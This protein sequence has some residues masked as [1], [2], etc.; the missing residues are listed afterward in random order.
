MET[1]VKTSKDGTAS[2]VVRRVQSEKLGI[3]GSQHWWATSSPETYHIEFNGV[4]DMVR[5]ATEGAGRTDL[6]PFNFFNRAEFVGRNFST[7]A[8]IVKATDN[9]W[10]LGVDR[11][12]E[13]SRE[14]EREE[15]PRPT[16]IKRRRVWDETAGDEID[17]DR[18]RA[19]DPYFRDSK[20]QHASGPRVITII[21]QLGQNAGMKSDDL[22]WRGA[23]AITL[24][25]I[26]EDAGYRTEIIAFTSGAGTTQNPQC[27]NVLSSVRLKEAGDML[28]V[29]SLV[30]VTSG[31]FF[32]TVSFASWTVPGERLS[33]GLGSMI[34]ATPEMVAYLAPGARPW[35]V[36]GV[37]N[38]ENS[39]RLARELLATLVQK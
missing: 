30:N 21:I 3:V 35:V 36:S 6:Y 12:E 20:R 28:D 24:A 1:Q 4:G 5:L 38:K 9:V 11:V 39:L 18:Y 23:L 14:L 7:F 10:T 17:F 16:V 29:S 15:L 31:W 32:R 2:A 34:E 26:V 8:E 37:Y 25:R 13:M 22:F 27:G 19:A 33:E